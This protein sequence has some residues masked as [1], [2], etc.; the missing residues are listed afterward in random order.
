MAVRR[1]CPSCSITRASMGVHRLCL[2]TNV[3]E[4]RWDLT[5]LARLKACFKWKH[6]SCKAHSMS[7]CS[8]TRQI[9]SDRQDIKPQ[10]R[11]TKLTRQTTSIQLPMQSRSKKTE[12]QCRS[13]TQTCFQLRVNS[14]AH[15]LCKAKPIKTTHT[16][17]ILY[18]YKARILQ[19]VR[20]PLINFIWS[21]SPTEATTASF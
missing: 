15:Q 4:T 10:S 11:A 6:L 16:P 5:T 12:K 8:L 19:L 1:M 3:S 14:L 20:Q 2:I 9:W 18:P 7:S 17:S 13:L 21:K